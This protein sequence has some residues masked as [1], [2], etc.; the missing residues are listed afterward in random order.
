MAQLNDGYEKNS[1]DKVKLSHLSILSSIKYIMSLYKKNYIIIFIMLVGQFM[2]FS[3]IFSLTFYDTSD[4]YTET[5]KDNSWHLLNIQKTMDKGIYDNYKQEYVGPEF[6]QYEDNEENYNILSNKIDNKL[7][8]AKQYFYNINFNNYL[9]DTRIDIPGS[10]VFEIFEPYNFMKILVVE[11]FDLFYEPVFLGEKPKKDNEILIYDYIADYLYEYG[12]IGEKII[13]ENIHDYIYD[14]DLKIAGVIKS[15]YK[16]YKEIINDDKLSY[17]DKKYALSHLDEL[18]TIICSPKTFEYLNNIRF[19]HYNFNEVFIYDESNHKK[20]K[21]DSDFHFVENYNLD[22]D[23][24][25]DYIADYKT[26]KTN[27][28]NVSGIVIS[29]RLAMKICGINDEEIFDY[30]SFGT[31]Y[32][33][34]E[35]FIEAYTI[36]ILSFLYDGTIE[37]EFTIDSSENYFLG[38]LDSSY[39]E[40]LL[41]IGKPYLI[42]KMFSFDKYTLLLSNNWSLNKEVI[43]KLQFPETK[44]NEFYNLQNEDWYEEN[45]SIYFSYTSFIDNSKTYL[46]KVRDL[47]SIISYILLGIS[48]L[49]ILL[50]SFLNIKTSIYKIGILESQGVSKINIFLLYF[51]SSFLLI[52]TAFLISIPFSFILMNYINNIFTSSIAVNLFFFGIKAVSLFLTFSLGIGITIISLIYPLIVLI[53]KSNI[54]II[55]ENK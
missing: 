35:A 53:R 49:F 51:F 38:V 29:K 8:I 26:E 4:A 36:H 5:L 6:Y 15:N 52:L 18:K 11:D 27:S 39:E 41:Y 55:N 30:S 13:S 42:R 12:I 3:N 40:S 19:N 44:T 48:I 37:P 14:T 33:G 31:E 7:P 23:Y 10:E 43:S 45:F 25:F 20:F 21:V 28:E 34:S 1:P 54:Q 22:I 16:D 24:S 46:T 2:L 17:L 47:S 32:V 50:Y 9:K